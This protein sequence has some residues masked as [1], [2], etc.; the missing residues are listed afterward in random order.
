MQ[1]FGYFFLTAK[2]GLLAAADGDS[3]GGHH[4]AL[5]R[6]KQCSVATVSQESWEKT[7]EVALFI[8][9]P[10]DFRARKIIRD[11]EGHPQ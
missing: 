7:A 2:S 1:T 5:P 6:L 9:D 3:R 11:N 8:S 10:V 4:A